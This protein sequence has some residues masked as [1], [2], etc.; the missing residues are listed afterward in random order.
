MD[1]QLSNNILT[2]NAWKWST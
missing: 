2:W 1:Y